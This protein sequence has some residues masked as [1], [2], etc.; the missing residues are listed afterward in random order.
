MGDSPSALKLTYPE[1]YLNNNQQE[2]IDEINANIENYL[3]SDI[4]YCLDS[5]VLVERTIANNKKRLGL[6]AAVDLESYEYTRVRA[7]IRATEDTIL[8]RLPVR[9]SIRKNASIELPHI[10]LLMDDDAKSIIEPIFAQKDKLE[11]LYDFELNMDGGHIIGYKVD[12][13]DELITKFD[14]L[15]DKSVQIKKYGH[16]AGIAFA[17]GD[18]NHSMATAKEHWNAIKESLSDKERLT[19]PARYCLVEILNIY[20][21]GVVFEP[22]HRVVF[23]K[24]NDKFIGGLK[25]ALKGDGNIELITSDKSIKLSCPKSSAQTISAVQEYIESSLIKNEIEVDYV[26]G[27]NHVK[28]VVSEKGGIGIIMPEFLP[29]ELFNYIINVGNLPKKAFSI[30]TA[31]NKK[32]YLEAKRI[33]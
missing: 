9:L 14:K 30:G 24:D 26:H 22:I 11:K 2:R 27:L 12:C 8:E 5:F 4:F 33:K 6:V 21:E 29:S 13:R 28:E 16:D 15:L 19:H 32:Y 23:A 10:I 31:E 7:G 3:A 20:D 18:G 1:I 17:V 25:N